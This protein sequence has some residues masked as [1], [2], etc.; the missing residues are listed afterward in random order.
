MD[1]FRG[2]KA[3]VT[4]A[5][6]GI[7]RA[8]AIALAREG[9]DLALVGRD[10][11]KL[12]A[13]AAEARS[14]GVE[15]MTVTCDLTQP[16]EITATVKSVLSECP[17][18]DILVNNAGVAYYGETDLLP[19]E[20][21]D[22]ILATNLLAPIQLIRE[23]LPTFIEQRQAHI[24]NVASMFGLVTM[25]KGAA[26]QASKFGLIGFSNAIRPEYWRR[27]ITV[28]VL[29]PGFVRTPML[30]LAAQKGR[31]IPDWAC[32]SPE[33][34]AD[35][36][37]RAIRRNKGVVVLPAYARLLWRLM[38]LSPGLFD[39]M[40]REGWRKRI[41]RAPVAAQVPSFSSALRDVSEAPPISPSANRIHT[42]VE[43]SDQAR[44]NAVQHN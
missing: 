11:A 38:R 41:N 3:L 7:G 13:T 25:R 21:F 20:E 8:I 12:K 14:L 44:L 22:K 4:G 35:A 15:A 10:E 32:S 34:V 18:L 31:A 6:S 36:A 42:L 24:L 19:T 33:Q 26:Y 27:G 43:P 40:T 2:K 1:S 30:E 23:L 39:W 17:R 16:A 5:G 37:L 9:V 28:T 29:C